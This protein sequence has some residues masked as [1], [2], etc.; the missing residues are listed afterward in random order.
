MLKLKNQNG[1]TIVEVL[2]VAVV[3]SVVIGSIYKIA[4]ASLQATQLTQERTYALKLAETQVERL[5][6]VSVQKTSSSV[7]DATQGFCI[8]GD[9]SRA[10]LPS[11]VPATSLEADAMSS[12]Q[13]STDCSEDPAS[14]ACASYCY[15]IGVTRTSSALPAP[16]GNSFNVS[17]R[18]YGPRGVKQQVQLAYK[19]YE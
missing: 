15:L 12:S 11:G 16:V 5:K 6:A 17:V 14:S 7:F 9:L 13:Y 3:L 19:V 2:I 8:K 10:D 1:D 18:W 4:T